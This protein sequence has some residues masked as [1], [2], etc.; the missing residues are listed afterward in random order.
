M[1]SPHND[2]QYLPEITCIIAFPVSAFNTIIRIKNHSKMRPGKSID[3]PVPPLKSH[4]LIND[5]P[6]SIRRLRGWSNMPII[7]ISARSE[8]IDKIDALY[9]GADDYLTKRSQHFPVYSDP[10]RHRLPNAE[11]RAGSLTMYHIASLRKRRP[12]AEADGL[13]AQFIPQSPPSAADGSGTTRPPWKTSDIFSTPNK[14][15]SPS[16]V[17][18]AGSTVGCPRRC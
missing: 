16:G 17:P 2:I 3:R 7:V 14:F 11:D 6:D 5:A 4:H 10:H 8:D 13:L 9:A 12:S 15:P 1:S 18:E